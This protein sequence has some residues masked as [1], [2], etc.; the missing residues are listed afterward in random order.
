MGG[1]R[2]VVVAGPG[3]PHGAP[4]VV[5]IDPVTTDAP[6]GHTIDERLALGELLVHAAAAVVVGRSV[7][8]VVV[9]FLPVIMYVIVTTSLFIVSLHGSE[10][11]LSMMG[12][13]LVLKLSSH[14]SSCIITG[15]LGGSVSVLNMSS[16]PALRF[17]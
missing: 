6:G 7:A 1:E 9:W 11:H 5:T 10:T 15:I 17:L 4:H 12:C 3:P 13:L 14:N 16:F 8:V 2:G